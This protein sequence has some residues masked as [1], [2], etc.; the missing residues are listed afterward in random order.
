MAIILAVRTRSLDVTSKTI[1]K[2]VSQRIGNKLYNRFQSA[3][4]LLR[5]HLRLAERGLIPIDDPDRLTQQLTE[6]IRYDTRYDWLAFVRPDGLGGGA[7]RSIDGRIVLHLI[8]PTNGKFEFSRQ[9]LNEDGTRKSVEALTAKV[10]DYRNSPWYLVGYSWRPKARI[11]LFML[12]P[13]RGWTTS[14]P[15]SVKGSHVRFASDTVNLT[16][17]RL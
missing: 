10:Y 9:I 2:E 1:Q 5:E 3:E 17:G 8:R 12:I 13:T 16:S 7:V 15:V 4:D 14:W 6:R 11:L